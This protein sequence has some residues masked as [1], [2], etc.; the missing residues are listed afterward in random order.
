MIIVA[1]GQDYQFQF[2]EVYMTFNFPGKSFSIQAGIDEDVFIYKV[3]ICII[4]GGIALYD[5]HVNPFIF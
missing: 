2:I 5:F 3:G 1:V 4:G